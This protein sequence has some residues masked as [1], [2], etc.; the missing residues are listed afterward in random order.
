MTSRHIPCRRDKARGLTRRRA[1]T[2]SGAALGLATVPFGSSAAL[3]KDEIVTWNGI[4]LG[5]AAQMQIVHTDPREAR[6][7]LETA[8]AE[9]RRLENI[10]SIYDETSDL[11]R[12]NQSGVLAAPPAQLVEVLSTALSLA[13]TTSGAFDPGVQVLWDHYDQARGPGNSLQTSTSL[14]NYRKVSVSTRE[15]RFENKA[16]ALTLNGIAQGYITDQIAALLARAGLENILIDCGEVFGAGVHPGGRA[17]KV[18]L[19]DN[20]VAPIACRN[21]AVATSSGMQNHLFDPANGQI[22]DRYKSL[23][24]IAPSAILADSLSTAFSVLPEDGWDEVLTGLRGHDVRVL[25]ARSDGTLF[26]TRT[27]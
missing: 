22:T 12:L 18:A 16:M 14:V 15:I 17:W 6:H 26:Q 7:I 24:V 20:P 5:A 11:A 9:L 1:L 25:G 2:I 8:V 4:A 10:F 19:A 21:Q 27:T 23:S 13:R 3:A